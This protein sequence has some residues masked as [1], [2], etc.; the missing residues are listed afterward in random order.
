MK[1]TGTNQDSIIT[2]G[3]VIPVAWDNNGNPMA[4]ALSTYEEKEYLINDETELGKELMRMK[5][6]KIR[7]TGTLG[8]VVNNRRVMTVSCYT[9]L[10]PSSDA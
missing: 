4:F 9:Q 7:V 8:G 6:Q 10:P 2:V 3:V 1:K 5:K